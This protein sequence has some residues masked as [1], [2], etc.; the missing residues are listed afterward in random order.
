MQLA[1]AVTAGIAVGIATLFYPSDTTAQLSAAATSSW[2]DSASYDTVTTAAVDSMFPI[3]G[4]AS[5]TVMPSG[6]WAHAM[7]SS[8]VGTYPDNQTYIY[9][10]SGGD[11]SFANTSALS[12]YDVSGDVWSS[13]TPIPTSRTQIS[14]VCIGGKIYVPGGYG[15][16]FSPTTALSVYDIATDQWQTAA[17]LPH[18][19]GDY[20][21]GAYADRYIYVIGGY[22]GSGDLNFVQIY[23]TTTNS[24]QDATAKPGTATAGLR[25]GIAG[26]QIVI[27]GGYSQTLG[28]EVADA[29][30]GTID[31]T[32]PAVVV[33]APIDDY[34]G[35]TVGR[36]GAGVLAA[37][38]PAQGAAS[39]DF[40]VFTGGD[41][42]G[43]GI[44][45]KN[46]TWIYDLNENIW[47]QAPDK[48]T[49][50]SNISNI[51]GVSS[52]G[53]LH[54]VT[55]GGYNGSSV[56]TVNEWLT[57]GYEA[58]PDLALTASADSDVVDAGKP[59]VYTLSYTVGSPGPA[60][61]VE[62]SDVV[63]AGTT[64]NS[65]LSSPGWTCTPDNSAGSECVLSLGTLAEDSS[66]AVT[67]AIDTSNPPQPVD[68]TQIDNEAVITTV[69]KFAPEQNS[70]NNTAS[71][72]TL[73]STRIFADGFELAPPI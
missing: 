12:R 24:W 36:L 51:A 47:K 22:S 48:L 55:T 67:F 53:K 8:T 70:A 3:E 11:A 65:G 54:I 9:V 23:D 50:E 2:H 32:N 45:V 43:Q 61:D 33:W 27:A 26:N 21:I 29:Y 56:T 34:P 20:A 16:S 59:L 4:W 40:V 19:T 66:G 18:A 31:P 7:A 62:I 5:R 52:G 38:G 72:T 35:G 13:L 42:D 49:G 44:S 17:P 63:P 25:G 58:P 28:A 41:P 39:L 10:I 57:F 1:H 64:F 73:Y 60:D 46:D 30:V 37:A 15:G 71:V 6:R 69:A 68:A 14:A